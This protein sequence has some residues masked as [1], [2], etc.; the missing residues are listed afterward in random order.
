M[1]NSLLSNPLNA[2]RWNGVEAE[3]VKAG[4]GGP[5]ETVELFH[6][7]SGVVCLRV[8]KEGEEA[9]H[10][11]SRYGV[12]APKGG[13]AAGMN[14]LRTE[15]LDFAISEDGAFDLSRPGGVE[16]L[17]GTVPVLKR[18]GGFSFS[19]KLHEDDRIYGLGDLTRDR[20]E[21][22]GLRDA[23]WV[24]NV[25]SYAPMPV[26]W[27]SR[28]WGIFIN[29]TWKTEL[30]LDFAGDSVV[31]VSCEGGTPEV[32][33]FV[34]DSP[35]QMLSRITEITGRPC[36]LPKWAYGLTF[37]CNLKANAREVLDDALAMRREGIPCDALG[38]E[39]GWMSVD[40]D[41]STG[42]TWHPERFYFSSWAPQD[43]FIAALKRL[44]FKLS[45]WLCSDYDLTWEEERAVKKA[46]AESRADHGSNGHHPDDFEKDP[47]F[48]HGPC[49]M[50]KLT[51]RDEPWF[52]HL[53]QFVDAGARAFKMDGALQ[54]N[55]H[56]D[57]LWGGKYLDAEMHNLYPTLLSKQM[58]EGFRRHCGLRPMVYSSGGY[59]GIQR[60]AA[61]WAG[62]TGGGAKPL[63]SLMN[64]GMTGHSN[65]SC[66]MQVTTAEGIHFGFLQPWSQ[67]N[68]WAY[69]RHPWLLGEKLNAIFKAYAC[70]RSRLIPY[71]Y[72]LAHEAHETGMPILRAMPLVHP[73]LPDSDECLNQYY[74]GPSLLV[75]A[76][77]DLILFP[78]GEWFDYWTKQWAGRHDWENCVWPE[79]RGGLLFVRAGSVLPMAPVSDFIGQRPEEQLTLEV[80]PG[81]DTE[82]T[83]CEDDGESH[84]FEEGA[85]ARTVFALKSSREAG[86]L[87]ITRREGCYEGMSES[88]TF[89]FLVYS[90]NTPA[91]VFLNDVPLEEGSGWSWRPD[92]NCFV[93]PALPGA[94]FS[95]GAFLKWS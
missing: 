81:G 92:E 90:R 73:E 5:S 26:F 94:D 51:V 41:Y 17:A 40:Y 25:K 9:R 38:L 77:T 78:E 15:H 4:R 33:F 27:S 53:R 47:H 2:S 76:F 55:E 19:L 52:D 29:T 71:I 75:G 69:W 6:A 23:A 11:L 57:R 91:A 65:T 34:A 20:L 48:G 43:T 61:T 30:D 87:R 35:A 72:S 80:F 46:E 84:A 88:R 89:E 44:G 8:R 32:F 16:L 70:L 22:R 85:V 67:V 49:L 14:R 79:D 45:L 28:G 18:R 59:V 93:V 42:K 64:H 95:A 86:E 56:P 63:V 36:L 3:S 13:S 24:W 39:P 68:S 7:G 58:Y 1:K 31:Q 37:V 50:D 62:D 10:L 60:Y 21:M 54:V 74:L 82:F 83:L 12:V 66:D